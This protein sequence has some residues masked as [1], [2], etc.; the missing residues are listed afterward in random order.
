MGDWESKK[1]IASEY[2]K[3]AEN[4]FKEGDELT[5]CSFQR[6]A[7]LYGIEATKSLISA[8]EVNGTKDG[9]ENLE[10]GLNKWREL[11]DFC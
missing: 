4:A 6:K 2:L 7:S 9:L 1:T 8:M 3:Q 11:G 10:G 5:G